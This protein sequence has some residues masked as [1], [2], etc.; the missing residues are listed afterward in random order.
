MW[1]PRGRE[2]STP[3]TRATMKLAS[4]AIQLAVSCTSAAAPLLEP[5]EPLP[6]NVKQ[7][8]VRAKLGRQL[9]LDVRLSANSSVSCSSCHDLAKGGADGRVHSIGFSGKQ[10]AVNSPTIL[11]ATFNFKQFWNG[12]A[13]SLEAQV[14][15]VVQNP[16][17]MGSKW[18]DVVAK[19]SQDPN[20]Q[21]AFASSYE[22]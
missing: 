4:F 3:R 1:M 11:N 21:R 7:D 6:I 22:N 10:T 14:D 16:I 17:E 2:A 5:I 18:D 15:A 8:P 13:D 9:F 12:R 19:V 20:Y